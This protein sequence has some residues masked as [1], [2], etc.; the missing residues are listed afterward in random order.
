MRKFSKINKIFFG[1]ALILLATG[2]GLKGNPVSPTTAGFQSQGEQKLTATAVENAVM[3]AWQFQD[4]AGK[5]SHINIEKSVLGSPGNVCRDCPR[6]FER[7]AQL[8]VRKD[9]DEYRLRDASVA[10]GKIYSYRLKLC[11]EAGICQESQIVEIDFK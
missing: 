6:V 2:C 3:L 8:P 1:L 11:N 9:N 5:I 10:K 4:M 7:I